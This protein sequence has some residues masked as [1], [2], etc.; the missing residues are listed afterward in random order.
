MKLKR[1]LLNA[2]WRSWYASDLR[3]VGP[4]WLQLVWTF[5][6]SV[7]VGLCFFV[8]SLTHQ[9][10]GSGRW[11]SPE[12]VGRW[13]ASNMVVALT[14]GYTIHALFAVLTRLIGFKRIGRFN[15]TQRGL[16]FAGV[17]MLGTAAGWPLGAWFV[18]ESA[19][20]VFPFERPSAVA[21]AML[22]AI[23]LS[24]LFYLHF[25][26]KSRQ[27]EA[28]KR[29]TEAQLRLLQ[30]QIEPHFL[31]NTLANVLALIEHDPPKARHTLEAFTEYLRASLSGL[32][33]DDNPLGAELDLATCRNSSFS[34]ELRP[35]PFPFSA[36][37]LLRKMFRIR[38]V[39]CAMK[40]IS[41]G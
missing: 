18:S 33:R 22:G 6:F 5:L 40:L 27:I 30:G 16:F 31:F 2:S 37:R 36:R 15:P 24:L 34:L 14:I 39:F 25:E 26:A 1:E 28:E 23:L 4:G 41:S 8:L 29:A 9:L 38:S 35:I 20:R 3:P 21:G 17:P 32:R 7:A 12:I 11:L 19:G 13:F 10:I